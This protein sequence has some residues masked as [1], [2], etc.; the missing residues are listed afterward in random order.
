M[1]IDFSTATMLQLYAKG[2]VIMIKRWQEQNLKAALN[3]RRGVHLTDAR[4][5]G[6]TT[7]SHFVSGS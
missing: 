7:L 6:K 4:Q 1:L 2:L 5:T 3:E